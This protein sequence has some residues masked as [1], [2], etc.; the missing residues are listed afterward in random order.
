MKVVRL[1]DCIDEIKSLDNNGFVTRST[2]HV[3]EDMRKEIK[4]FDAIPLNKVKQ[5]REE[6]E[7]LTPWD[8]GT[9]E[10]YDVLEVLDKLI[11]SEIKE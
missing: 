10:M 11:E 5:A 9:V 6:I 4:E 8:E 7:N 3:C 1:E 2:N